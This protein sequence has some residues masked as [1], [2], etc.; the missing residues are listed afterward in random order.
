MASI[1]LRTAGFTL[2]D[3]R[4]ECD[5]CGGKFTRQMLPI[6]KCSALAEPV[7]PIGKAST[8]VGVPVF[9]VKKAEPVQEPVAWMYT[10][11][12]QDGTEH[13]PHLVWKPAYMDSMSASKGA[14]ATPLY[15]APPPA[16]PVQ[17]PQ[18]HLLQQALEALLMMR[19]RYGEYACPACDHADAAIKMMR[20]KK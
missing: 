11:I 20:S 6:H 7:P 2:R 18:E 17:E 1:D 10:G 3:T 9:V 5:E 19:D 8:D 16:E 13:G 14:Q 15:T 12:K 4:L